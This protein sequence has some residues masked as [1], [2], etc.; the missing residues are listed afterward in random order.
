MPSSALWFFPIICDFGGEFECWKGRSPLSQEDRGGVA[1]GF[2]NVS[3][4]NWYCKYCGRGVVVVRLLATHQG[5][6]GS[7]PGRVAP[8]FLHVPDDA[9]GRRIF[10]GTSRFPSPFAIPALLGT[11][12]ASPRR[13]FQ[14]S[15]WECLFCVRRVL[16]EQSAQALLGSTWRGGMRR[17]VVAPRRPH[18]LPRRGRLT[19]SVAAP[20]YDDNAPSQFKQ[21]L[22]PGGTRLNIS[23]SCATKC[24]AECANR[25]Y[26][27]D[28]YGMMPQTFRDDGEGHQHPFEIGNPGP[29]K[30]QSDVTIKRV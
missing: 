26:P 17:C 22:A 27:H 1:P 19:S 30:T 20:E 2:T 11:Q 6:P 28:V 29:E 18:T 21:G 4:L 5:E 9:A 14:T 15:I 24:P 3:M 8:G 13:L 12:L 7:I 23:E 10:S 25:P 16:Q